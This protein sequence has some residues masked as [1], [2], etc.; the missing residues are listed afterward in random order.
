MTDTDTKKSTTFKAPTLDDG[1]NIWRL[2]KETGTL[3]LNSSYA[4]LMWCRDFADTSIVAE[5]DGRFGGFVTGYLRPSSPRTLMVWQVA[6]DEAMRGKGIASAMLNELFDRCATQ[7]GVTAMETTITADNEASINLFTRFAR[8]WDLE[9]HRD[10]LFLSH[11][12]PDAH[13]TEYL[14]RIG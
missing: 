14:Y 12:F 7:H 13:E 9:L 4:Y 2:A 6:T 10:A 3:D 5:H 11:T 8:H 1:A